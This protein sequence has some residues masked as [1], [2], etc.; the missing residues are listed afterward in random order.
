MTCALFRKTHRA[1]NRSRVGVLTR[2]SRR[3]CIYEKHTCNPFRMRTFKTLDVEPLRI[4]IYEKT[5]G[6]GLIVNHISE[7][8]FPSRAADRQR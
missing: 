3:I 8:G 2:K 5:S 6:E 4:R 7:E 1:S